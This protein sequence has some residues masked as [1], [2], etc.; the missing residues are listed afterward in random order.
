SNVF[1]ATPKI[2]DTLDDR[3]EVIPF[4]PMARSFIRIEIQIE[5]RSVKETPTRVERLG[6]ED[7]LGAAFGKRKIQSPQVE[8]LILSFAGELERRGASAVRR[9]THFHSLR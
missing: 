9:Q 2:D 3:S 6:D 8:R 5:H 7:R 4:D 1:L